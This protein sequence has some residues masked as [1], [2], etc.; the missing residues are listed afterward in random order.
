MRHSHVPEDW[1]AETALDVVAFLDHVIQTI[2]D[3]HGRQM[4]L[5]LE[6]RCLPCVDPAKAAG[7]APHAP[8]NEDG[9]PF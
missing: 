7:Y 2:W 9:I 3:I 8:A 6:R 5:C 4:G 1:T